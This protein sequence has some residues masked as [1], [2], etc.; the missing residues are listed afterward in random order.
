[1]PTLK[2][3]FRFIIMIILFGSL[4]VA[5]YSYWQMGNSSQADKLTLIAPS[6]SPSPSATPQP[7]PSGIQTY[8]L[9]HG[10]NVKGPKISS[11]TIDPV[12]ASNGAEQTVTLDAR[13]TSA[14][15]SVIVEVISDTQSERHELQKLSGS[16]NNG[17]WQG[18]WLVQDSINR[19]YGLRF[20]LTS[21]TETY[22]DIMWYRI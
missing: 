21:N 10:P 20:I 2:L 13:F 6:P 16:P 8:N 11:L 18:K 1:M 5:I 15:T 12:D 3:P 17:T 4:A 9:Q 22:D 19:K 7:I 14:I